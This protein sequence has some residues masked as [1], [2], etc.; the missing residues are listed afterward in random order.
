MVESVQKGRLRNQHPP[1]S[2]FFM[3]END[4]DQKITQF[5]SLSISKR[6]YHELKKWQCEMFQLKSVTYKNVIAAIQQNDRFCGRA[7]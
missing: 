4:T 2:T 1:F 7:V 5:M 3:V 6:V